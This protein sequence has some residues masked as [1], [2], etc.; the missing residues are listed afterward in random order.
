MVRKRK[1]TRT[2]AE[3]TAESKE[4]F[5]K[6]ARNIENVNV[7]D[8]LKSNFIP[9]AWSYNLDRALVDVSGLKPVQRRI[10]WT[11]Y[12]NGLSP[13]STRMK[14]STISGSVLK[15]HPHD[16]NAVDGSLEGMAQ[17]HTCRVPLVDG[18]G[19]FG[20]PGSEAAAS[21][22]IEARLTPAGWLNVE[23]IGKNA[24]TMIPSYDNTDVE[25]SRIPVKWPVG[26]VNGGSGMARLTSHRITQRRSCKQARIS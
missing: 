8:W 19:N 26:V 7:E 4:R 18:K 20:S 10:L 12:K 15:F 1:N 25:P 24:V 16:S 21:R 5:E 11:M 22:Y 6:V 13:S 17:E 14:V 3:L 2:S 9:Y 23:D